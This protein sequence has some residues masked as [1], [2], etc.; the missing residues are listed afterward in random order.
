MS[1]QTVVRDDPA[2]GFEG[3]IAYPVKT[4]IDPNSRF[5]KEAAGIPF[6]RFVVREGDQTVRLPLATT[7]I[8]LTKQTG[9]TVRQAYQ[10]ANANGYKDGDPAAIVY[11]GY[12]W[13]YVE[14][15]AVSDAPV[16]CRIAAGGHGVGSAM[17][18]GGIQ[19]PGATFDTSTS[20][21]GLVIVR[22]RGT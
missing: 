10:E 17:V 7:E 15:A 22:L 2:I 19:V 21:A 3:Q 9:V 12:V 5:V 8:D 13:M 18:S 11:V 6:G 16:F 14:A 4:Y 20:G 1:P